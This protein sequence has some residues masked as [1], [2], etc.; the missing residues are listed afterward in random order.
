MDPICL[1][2]KCARTNKVKPCTIRSKDAKFTLLN[3]FRQNNL[4]ITANFLL[5]RAPSNK[6]P[7]YQ[8]IDYLY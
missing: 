8:L 3:S 4:E 2:R 6:T 5:L 1:A 7:H